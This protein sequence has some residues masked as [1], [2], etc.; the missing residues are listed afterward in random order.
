MYAPF[1]TGKQ[2]RASGM[3]ISAVSETEEI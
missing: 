2:N 3:R 1:Q